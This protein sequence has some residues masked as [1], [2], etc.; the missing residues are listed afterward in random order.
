MKKILICGSAGFL[1]AN[2][3]RYMLYRS[4]DFDFVSIDKLN[5]KNS[6]KNIYLNKKHNFHIGDAANIDFMEKVINIENP[7]VVILATN[8][9]NESYISKINDIVL[10]TSVICTIFKKHIIRIVP[11]IEIQNDKALWNFVESI[12]LKN[13]GTVVR[14]PTCFGKRGN[15]LFEKNIENIIKKNDPILDSVEKRYVYS[16]DVSSFLWFIIE[17]NIKNKTVNMPAL[18]KASLYDIFNT[19][20]EIGGFEE[21]TLEGWIPDSISMRDSVQKTIKWY[22]M[23]NWIFS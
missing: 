21:S 18:G 16:D 1:M 15:G 4:K 17:N 2:T 5:S 3:I 7:D 20:K 8:S 22:S 13:E 10:P 14:L 11:D 19:S 9:I 23:N 12:V 6:Y